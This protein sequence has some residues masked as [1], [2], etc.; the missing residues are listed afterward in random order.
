[1]NTTPPTP[2]T[3]S[4]LN[5]WIRIWHIV[6]ITG[7][8]IF[9]ALAL[10]TTRGAWGATTVA[11]VGIV[12]VLIALYARVLMLAPSWPLPA[13]QLALYY[14]TTIGLWLVL[15]QIN[16]L[17]YY[18]IGM[19]IGQMLGVLP[20]AAAL[21]GVAVLVS[22]IVLSSSDWRVNLAGI[23]AGDV[24]AVAVPVAFSFLLYLYIYMIIRSNRQ[25]QTLVNQLQAAN[26]AL[27]EAREQEAELAALRERE[28]VARDLHDGLGHSLVALSIQLEATQRLYQVDPERA[29]AQVDDMKQLT[30]DSMTQLRDTLAGLRAPGLGDQALDVAIT[31]RAAALAET[32]PAVT[33]DIDPAVTALRPAATEA[34]WRVAAEALANVER[35]AGA[36]AV[37]LRLQLSPTA[38]TLTVEDDG[39]G[40]PPDAEARPGH[41]GLR[42]MR[43]R[44]EGLGGTLAVTNTG[45]GT[46]V[47]AEIPAG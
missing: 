29:S 43:E 1:M 5:R 45:A 7:L 15:L 47:S 24:L 11:M 10:W 6:Y 44:V 33:I 39:R 32:G 8:L 16:P 4:V 20:A 30:R 13:W 35:H 18:G 40:L 34:L 36:T 27:A 38:A 2:P 46:R 25:T 42:G 21:P 31:E 22:L 14:L 23:S 3:E 17:F 28:R 37:S 41:Y 19:V 9:A 26:Q 12:A